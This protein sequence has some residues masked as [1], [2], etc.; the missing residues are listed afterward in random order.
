MQHCCGYENLPDILKTAVRKANVFYTE[1][2]AKNTIGRGQQIYYVWTD[3]RIQEVRV[4]TKLGLRAAI[5]ESESF[6]YHGE[7]DERSFLNMLMQELGTLGVQWTLCANT[8]RFQAY[9]DGSYVAPCGNYMI[10]LTMPEEELWRNVHSKH[11]NSIRRGEKSELEL[12]FGGAELLKDYVPI[13]KETYERSGNSGSGMEYYQ[14]LMQSMGSSAFIVMAYKEGEPQAGGMFYYNEAMGYYLHGASV[15]R[16]EP[17]SANYLL[18]R[19]I[20]RLKEQGTQSFSFVGYHYDPEPNSKL[21]GI[22]RF[23]ERFGGYLEKSY[24]FRYEQNPLAYRLYCLAMRLQSGKPFQK[25][26]DAID[27]QL[28]RYP[29]LNGGKRL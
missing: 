9:P 18:W 28:E 29:E 13:E 2:Y 7:E 3:H 19:T 24:N 27:K 23:K 6:L 5:L 1:A 12:K 17:G 20:L 14:G 25:Y 4:K 16:P 26:Q 11:R 10:D 8:A 21:E 15:G 22:Q